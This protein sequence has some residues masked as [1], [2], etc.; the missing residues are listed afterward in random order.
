MVRRVLVFVVGTQHDGRTPT[1]VGWFLVSEPRLHCCVMTSSSDDVSNQAF[2]TSP[3]NYGAY[4]LRPYLSV[5]AAALNSRKKLKRPEKTREKCATDC[6]LLSARRTRT[7]HSGL[8]GCSH[9]RR[10]L[11]NPSGRISVGGLRQARHGRTG[12]VRH[13]AGQGRSKG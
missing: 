12:N 13:K 8:R 7:S 6:V 3:Q 2:L 1:N 10:N 9:P 4:L 11:P 5:Y